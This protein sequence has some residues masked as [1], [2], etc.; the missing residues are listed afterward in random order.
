MGAIHPKRAWHTAKAT[1]QN[2]RKSKVKLRGRKRKPPPPLLRIRLAT[3]T[4]SGRQHAGSPLIHSN[5]GGCVCHIVSARALSLSSNSVKQLTPSLCVRAGVE[6]GGNEHRARERAGAN[7]DDDAETC[8]WL[9]GVRMGAPGLEC[10]GG[11]ASEYAALV[12]AAVTSQPPGRCLAL[13]SP[14]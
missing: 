7:K 4:Q 13:T 10:G 6:I 11:R 12:G 1:A 9:A 14:C 3:W 8:R 2:S 5:K